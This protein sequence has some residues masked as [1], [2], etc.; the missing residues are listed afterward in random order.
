MESGHDWCFR[1]VDRGWLSAESLV[2]GAIDLA[3]L[4]EVNEAIDVVEENE[5][6]VRDAK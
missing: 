4:A 2:N 5:R 6:R 3:F 1:P